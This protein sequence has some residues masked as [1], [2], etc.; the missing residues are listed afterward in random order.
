MLVPAR[1]DVGED[2]DG[3]NLEQQRQRASARR[4]TLTPEPR[5]EAA[6][7]CCAGGS[8]EAVCVS[9]ACPLPLCGAYPIVGYCGSFLNK[10]PLPNSAL[11]PFSIPILPSSS[12]LFPPGAMLDTA[13][14]RADTV[15][16]WDYDDRCKPST[17]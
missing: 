4:R 12:P 13:L 15:I 11:T 6:L 17:L 3:D 5:R 9:R 7:L 8:G 2:S 14:Q 10:L 1:R 16:Y